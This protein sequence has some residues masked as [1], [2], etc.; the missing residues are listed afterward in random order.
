MERF[1]KL[2][3]NKWVEGIGVAVIAGVI[4]T[5]IT[6]APNEFERNEIKNPSLSN[7]LVLQGSP[8]ATVNY[9]EPPANQTFTGPVQMNTGGNNTQINSLG[10]RREYPLDFPKLASFLEADEINKSKKILIAAEAGNKDA[11]YAAE[12][13][14]RGLGV[15]GFHVAC[16][17]DSVQ[18]QTMLCYV[19]DRQLKQ[20]LAEFEPWRDRKVTV[21]D[22]VQIKAI[23]EDRIILWVGE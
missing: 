11:G 10:Q 14:A 19:D 13:M 23:T 6:F 20:F 3:A 2:L 22:G 8:G 21:M 12:S 16:F 17:P 15:S 18:I 5:Y 4:L 7:S 1:K 9:L